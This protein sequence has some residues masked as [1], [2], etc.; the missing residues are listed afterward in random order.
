MTRGGLDDKPA[1]TLALN[2][3]LSSFEHRFYEHRRSSVVLNLPGLEVFPGDLLVS[4]GT[5]DYLYHPL[6]LLSPGHVHS[7]YTH[8]MP[9]IAIGQ[10]LS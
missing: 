5:A 4:D 6:L 8:G 1:G 7:A 2:C 10:I 9:A 3:H